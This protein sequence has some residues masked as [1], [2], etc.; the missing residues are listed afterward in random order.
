MIRLRFQNPTIASLCPSVVIAILVHDPKIEQGTN[1]RRYHTRASLIQ[2]KRML[3]IADTIVFQ[4][5]TKKRSCVSRIHLKCTLIQRDDF[6]QIPADRSQCRSALKRILGMLFH[7]AENIVQQLQ[8]VVFAAYI[9]EHFCSRKLT[10]FRCVSSPLCRIVVTQRTF[11]LL[12]LKAAFSKVILGQCTAI[13]LLK[14]RF[15]VLKLADQ[16]H[17]NTQSSQCRG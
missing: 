4:R 2:L 16:I 3:V 15:R 9:P 17:A 5:Q 12:K 11:V 6:G 13:G 1:V 14:C 7:S 10:P 8:C